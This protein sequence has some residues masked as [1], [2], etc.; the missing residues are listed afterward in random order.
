M[1]TVTVLDDRGRVVV[2]KEIREKLGLKGGAALI[3]ESKGDT[4]ILR[5]MKESADFTWDPLW[6][7]VHNP[8][9]PKISLTK[10]KLEKLEEELWTV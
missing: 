8:A 2:P 5:T 4:I 7:A 1:L 3:L 6:S 9:K 10:D